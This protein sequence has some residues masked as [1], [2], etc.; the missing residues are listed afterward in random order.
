MS[1]GGPKSRTTIN[2][3]SGY[4]NAEYVSGPNEGVVVDLSEFAEDL[5]NYQDISHRLSDEQERRIVD[6]VKSMVDMSYFKI[7]KR[8]SSSLF[9]RN[10]SRN[11]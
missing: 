7:R 4:R 10:T 9:W 11:K 2:S 1:V 6:Y 3:G 8:T 5:V